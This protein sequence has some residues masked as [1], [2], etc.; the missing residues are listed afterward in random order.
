[1]AIRIISGV[2]GFPILLAIVLLGGIWLKL[3]VLFISLVGIYEF[4]KAVSKEIKPIHFIGFLIEIVYIFFID[5]QISEKTRFVLLIFIILI[6]IMSVFM[7]SKININDAA[8]TLFGFFYIGFLLSNVLLIKNSIYGDYLVWLA[9][10]CAWCCD[11][12]AYFTGVMFGKH[13]MAPVLS[14]HKTI[15]GAIGGVVC[16]ALLSFGYG[17]IISKYLNVGDTNI[18]IIC[19]IIGLIG[20]M[21]SQLGDLTASSIKRYTGIKDFGKIMPGHGGVLDRFDSVIFTS[22]I[23]YI[24]TQLMVGNLK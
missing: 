23:V 9:F 14:P 13:K 3:G 18:A 2:V 6:L 10:I 22:P 8:V 4:Y 21:F 19:A 1:M 20:S 11:T 5:V 12:G 17:F 7:H 24:L 16:T 15:E